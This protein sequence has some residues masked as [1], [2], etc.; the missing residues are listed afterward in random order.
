[1]HV[2]LLAVL[3][4]LP[5]GV[6]VTDPAT[7][8]TA[9]GRTPGTTPTT[10]T[11]AATTTT[12]TSTTTTTTM[13]TT[14]T[15]VASTAYDDQWAYWGYLYS[16]GSRQP[17]GSYFWTQADYKDAASYAR[18]ARGAADNGITLGYNA[19][20]NPYSITPR[21]HPPIPDMTEQPQQAMKAFLSAVVEDEGGCTT[22]LI[23]DTPSLSV[24]QYLQGL[25]TAVGVPSHIDTNKVGYAW[26][27]INASDYGLI[28]GWPYATTFRTPAP[29][30][31]Q[32][33]DERTIERELTRFRVECAREGARNRLTS[34][35]NTTRSIPGRRRRRGLGR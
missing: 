3:A 33:P 13:P 11:S 8:A 35:G 34:R 20:G 18:F 21:P 1:M 27:R 14:T 29:P 16:D 17:N 4:A 24:A 10:T 7:V 23:E 30:T 31:A 19:N 32:F 2:R 9:W 26:L 12:S 15:T 22:G 25:L 6:T 28:Q 5:A